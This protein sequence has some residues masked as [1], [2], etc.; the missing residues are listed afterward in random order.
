MIPSCRYEDGSF[1][2]IS[3]SYRETRSFMALEKEKPAQNQLIQS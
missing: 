1:L 3:E 2:S